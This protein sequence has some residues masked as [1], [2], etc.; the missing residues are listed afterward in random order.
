MKK[1]GTYRKHGK[2]GVASI[3]ACR[4]VRP[5]NGYDSGKLMKCGK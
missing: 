2:I 5:V 1:I 4:Y 3:H